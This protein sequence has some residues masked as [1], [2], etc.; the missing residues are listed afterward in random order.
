MSGQ[1]KVRTMT[2]DELVQKMIACAKVIDK[3]AEKERRRMARC[4]K[5]KRMSRKPY[6]VA[7]VGIAPLCENRECSD[8]MVCRKEGE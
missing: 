7:G 1:A 4:P 3:N 5:C 2:K 8:Y 6:V